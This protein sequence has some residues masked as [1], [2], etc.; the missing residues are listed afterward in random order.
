M[1][2]YERRIILYNVSE[3]RKTKNVIYFDIRSKESCLKN[4]KHVINFDMYKD[5]E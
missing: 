2:N 3:T 4:E 5:Y 1:K